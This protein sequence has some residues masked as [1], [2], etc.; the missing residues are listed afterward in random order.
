MAE[1]RHGQ[2]DEPTSAEAAGWDRRYRDALLLWSGC[3]PRPGRPAGAPLPTRLRT[4]WH[5]RHPSSLR[6]LLRLLVAARD[7]AS[8]LVIRDGRVREWRYG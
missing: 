6:A 4:G 5:R 2:S 1:I 3:P 8:G 7:R